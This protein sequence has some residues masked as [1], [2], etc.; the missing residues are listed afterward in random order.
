MEQHRRRAS[1]TTIVILMF[2]AGLILGGMMSSYVLIREINSLEDE[3]SALQSQISKIHGDQNI[4]EQNITIYQNNVSLTEI[5]ERVKDSVVLIRGKND[6]ATVQGSGFVYNY[7]GTIV[8]ITNNH[9]VHGTNSLSITFSNGNGYAAVINGTDPYSDLAVLSAPSAPSTEFKPLE[10]VSST[11]LRVGNQVLAVG[12]PYGLVGSMTTGVVSAL[13]RTI[14]ESEY[15]GGF[16]IAN[17]IQ[18]SAPIN[19]GNS[20][21]PLLN[22]DGKVVGITTAIVA[23]SQG[24]GFAVP[25]NAILREIFSLIENGSYEGHPYL[26]VTGSDMDYETAQT[27]RVNVTYGWKIA[28]TVQGGPASNAGVRV[29]DIIIGINGIRIRNGDE[30]SSYLEE[31]TLPGQ[32]VDLSIARGNETLPMPMTLGHR[33]PPPA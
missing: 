30:M 10:I 7:T 24:L 29:N 19:P 25:S 14:D 18:T 27:L 5:Y 20:G 9:V 23:D 32:T 1:S 2:V 26:G 21:G 15:T 6:S 22:L 3:V 31:N 33:P 4:T 16:A 13:G 28:G 8:I 17:I 11:K 12:N